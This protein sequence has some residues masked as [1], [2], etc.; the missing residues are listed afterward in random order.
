M[1]MSAAAKTIGP[2]LQGDEP[3]MIFL[4]RVATI[5]IFDADSLQMGEGMR[6]GMPGTNHIGRGGGK[7]WGRRVRKNEGKEAKG[8]RRYIEIL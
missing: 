4:V 6:G 7:G 2:M 5:A 8:G 3:A 1:I